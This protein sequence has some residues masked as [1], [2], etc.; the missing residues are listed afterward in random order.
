MHLH[1][2]QVKMKL[3][4]TT[5]N[6]LASDFFM[7]NPVWGQLE[8][9][10]HLSA[11]CSYLP[12]FSQYSSYSPHFGLMVQCGR[13]AH[14]SETIEGCWG[15]N[16]PQWKTN[17]MFPWL[18]AQSIVSFVFIFLY[19]DVGFCLFTISFPQIEPSE[20]PLRQVLC[21]TLTWGL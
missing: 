17:N 9:C 10:R 5:K 21:C 2:M 3:S 18:K 12:A 7:L 4:A 16:F 13:S 15:K 6:D 14:F 20:S 19:T 8:L 1:T 11:V